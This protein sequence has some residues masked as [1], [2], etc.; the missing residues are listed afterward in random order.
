MSQQKDSSTYLLRTVR[1][2]RRNEAV[3]VRRSRNSKS[4]WRA[5][6]V[7][8]SALCAGLLFAVDHDLF[9][10]S[11]NGQR[12][13]DVVVPQPWISRVATAFALLAQMSFAAAVAASYY[14]RLWLNLRIGSYKVKHVDT[15]M[16]SYSNVFSLLQPRAWLRIPG[17]FVMALTI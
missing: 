4:T 10:R 6:G 14:Q 8:V 17:L 11:L 12:V 5:A 9:N 16:A 1:E 7:I 13:D 15:L 3:P 2:V